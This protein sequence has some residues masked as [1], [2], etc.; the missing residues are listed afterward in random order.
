MARRHWDGAWHV[1]DAIMND[2][3]DLV[4]RIVVRGR[5]RSLETAALVDRHVD[6]DGARLHGFQHRAR[7]EP[8]RTCSGDKDRADDDIGRGYLLIKRFQGREPRADAP[9]EEI[10]E[11]TEPRQRPV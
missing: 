4:S 10:V 11:F 9:L 3:V 2:A 7:N 5:T 8:G 6:D 1:G